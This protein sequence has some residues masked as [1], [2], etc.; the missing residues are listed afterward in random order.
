MEPIRISKCHTIEAFSDRLNLLHQE[1][2]VY[3][4]H[5]DPNQLKKKEYLICIRDESNKPCDNCSNKAGL[6][7][8]WHRDK[9]PVYSSQRIYLS[10]CLPRADS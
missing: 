1:G 8:L 2:Y 9:G 5:N 4:C 6:C 10:L 7:I 3:V